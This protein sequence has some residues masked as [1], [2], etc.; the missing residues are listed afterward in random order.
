MVAGGGY[1]LSVRGGELIA[2]LWPLMAWSEAWA[3]ALQALPRE[4]DTASS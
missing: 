2:A 3:A 1:G 4:A